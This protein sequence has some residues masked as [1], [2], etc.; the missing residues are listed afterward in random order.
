MA[1][2]LASTTWV[3][4]M[5]GSGKERGN[6][7]GVAR[8]SEGR[9]HRPTVLVVDDD[10]GLRTLVRSMLRLGGYEVLSA[11][12][13]EEALALAEAHEGTL[14]LLLTDIIMPGLQGPELAQRLQ[15]A[16]PTLRVLLMT[17]A[18]SAP[19]MALR[20]PFGVSALLAAVRS[21]LIDNPR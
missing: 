12:D 5:S 20:K 4:T 3:G 15:A 7:R 21:A 11:S 2:A 9:A 8:V 18:T 16:Y 19:P 17:G 10:E 1:L 6:E 14:D 13:A